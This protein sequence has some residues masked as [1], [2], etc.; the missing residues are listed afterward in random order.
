MTTIYGE[1]L[2]AL[3]KPCVYVVYPDAKLSPSALYVGM[4]A[5]G[6]ARIYDRQHRILSEIDGNDF[7]EVEFFDTVEEAIQREMELYLR[8]RPVH[9]RMKPCYG[10]KL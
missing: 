5:H 2:R 7:V 8:L 1:S 3:S 9:N 4:S 10:K 6:L